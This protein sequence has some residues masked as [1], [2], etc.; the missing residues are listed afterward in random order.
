MA[1]R[2]AD[3]AFASGK[4]DTAQPSP[5]KRAAGPR[6][7]PDPPPALYKASVK[8]LAKTK[9]KLDDATVHTIKSCLDLAKCPTT[10]E[11]VAKKAL[12]K[13]SQWMAKHNV[14]KAE[15]L[16][17]ESPSAQMQ[18]AGRSVVLLLRADGD[19]SKAVQLPSFVSTVGHAMNE[20][21][22][23]SFFTTPN[24]SSVECTFY[25][26]AENTVAAAMAFE[27]VYNL[28]VEWAR[29]HKGVGGKNSYY[30]GIFDELLK[31]ARKRKADEEHQAKKDEQEASAARAKRAP[32]YDA[33]EPEAMSRGDTKAPGEEAGDED[34]G[35]F[36]GNPKPLS[37][38]AS[39]MR[40]LLGLVPLKSSG[41]AASLCLTDQKPT[42]ARLLETRQDSCYPS[43]AESALVKWASHQQLVTFRATADKIADDYLQDNDLKLN[44]GR[45]RKDVIRDRDA[46]S[47][48]V[49][50]SKHID[51]HR[52][53]V[54]E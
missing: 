2:T 24:R 37:S 38:G 19:R 48:G 35:D 49:K 11:S 40:D 34:V 30:L 31:D 1:K 43:G 42:P 45:K 26:I 51:V 12:R 13:A 41:Q 17:H 32:A 54:G 9:T 47:Q 53:K 39:S 6:A 28:I 23:C 29:A 15:I 44:K 4:D 52:K 14:S 8:S 36:S 33:F 46:Y 20:S 50:D 3:A 21:F 5:R 27:M 10:I 16:S 25:G 22:D 18:H 7:P